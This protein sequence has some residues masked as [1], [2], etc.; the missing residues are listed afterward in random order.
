MDTT[1]A[2]IRAALEAVIDPELGINV[3][4]LG[5]IYRAEAAGKRIEVDLTTTSPGCPAAG[6]IASEVE[7]AL[8]AQFEDADVEVSLIWDPPWT[9]DRLS[10]AARQILGADREVSAV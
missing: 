4:D 8:R 6:R 2:Q 7:Q 1:T 9:P 3:V 5:L 10:P